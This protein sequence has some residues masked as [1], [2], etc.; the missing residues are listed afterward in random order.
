MACAPANTPPAAQLA[1]APN[2]PLPPAI[3][4]CHLPTTNL[5]WPWNR[6]APTY[7]TCQAWVSRRTEKSDI[8]KEMQHS[9]PVPS[10]CS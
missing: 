4:K 9:A 2:R 10:F 8:A 7:L 1:A 6:D 5:H 3:S